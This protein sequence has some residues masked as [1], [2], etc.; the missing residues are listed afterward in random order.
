MDRKMRQ[1][2]AHFNSLPFLLVACLL[3]ATSG[4][5]KDNP[6]GTEGDNKGT[7][8]ASDS[9][10]S[11]SDSGEG[12]PTEG[13]N[14]FTL[15]DQ[16]SKEDL[17]GD[18]PPDSASAA[19]L[20]PSQLELPPATD[21]PTLAQFLLSADREIQRLGTTEIAPN[22]RE[23]LLAELK[24]VAVLK[25]ETAE[26]I[27]VI[28][29]L[30]LPQKAVAIQARMQALSHRAALGD[31]KAADDLQAYATEMVDNPINDIARDS[32]TVLVG[33][34]LERLQSGLTKDAS[35][36]V[37]L[38]SRLIAAPDQLD[39][40]TLKVLQQTMLV[41]QQYGYSAES[42][43]VR[44]QIES[45]EQT[46]TVPALKSLA[47][48]ILAD[49]RFSVLESMRG[50]IAQAN[51]STAA[52]WYATALEVA[53]EH[54]DGNTLVYLSNLALQLEAMEHGDEAEAIYQVIEQQLAPV[55]TDGVGRGARDCLSARQARTSIIGK[56]LTWSAEETITSKPLNMQSML[57]QI[58]LIP[59]WGISDPQSLAP[60]SALE[61]VAESASN[62]I[63][64]VGICMDVVADA[65]DQA[66]FLSAERMPW[67][68]IWAANESG[69][70]FGNAMLVQAGVVSVPAVIVVD[71]KGLVAAVALSHGSVE[72]AVESLLATAP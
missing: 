18:I 68:S 32:R 27:L 2:A 57:G 10:E 42:M 70:P 28:A 37:T 59:V 54:P 20:N 53:T 72:K 19:L 14:R 35:E 21:F 69:N 30:D 3:L 8:N 6:S 17:V 47:N 66:K 41:L 4:C 44:Q 36:I 25:Q 64:I 65:R 58:V 48:S 29:D 67:P 50:T 60:L 56:P 23:A 51:E 13:S 7:A 71:Q 5:S 43:Q 38:T 62:R 12:S 40:S 49:A 26:R 46:L 61:Q 39:A 33:F 9:N 52:Q 55:E 22:Q 63:K 15:S 16:A 31:L 11:P 1:H 45:L 34:A 24:R